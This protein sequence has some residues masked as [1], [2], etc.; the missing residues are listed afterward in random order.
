MH[1]ARYVAAAALGAGAA[2]SEFAALSGGEQ[3]QAEV[4]RALWWCEEGYLE[5][6]AQ[7]EGG[8]AQKEGGPREGCEGSGGEA[9]IDTGAS[10]GA[11]SGRQPA[12]EGIPGRER[13][14]L[15]DEFGSSWDV[16]TASRVAAALA[17]AVRDPRARVAGAVLASCHLG[18]VAALQPDWVFEAASA[19]LLQPTPP[20]HASWV[21]VPSAE[22]PPPEE[23]EGSGDCGSSG[24]CAGGAAPTPLLD[25]P[26]GATLTEAATDI[27]P[28]S[29]IGLGGGIAAWEVAARR[30]ASGAAR[31]AASVVVATP[32]LDLR[33]RRCGAV[34]WRRFSALH[35]KSAALSTHA[36]MRAHL[37]TARLGEGPEVHSIVDFVERERWLT[38]TSPSLPHTLTPSHPRTLVPSHR[39]TLVLSHPRPCQVPC[40]FV[41]TI[42]HSGKRSE[43]ARAPSRRAHRTVV[44]AEWQG[45]GIGSRLSDA[46]AEW[47][48][49]E[50]ADYYGQT[51][52]PSF[53]GYRD[54]SPLWQPTEYNGTRPE[55]RIE[56]WRAR[57]RGVAVRLRTPKL[58]YSHRYC[59][60]APGDEVASRHLAGRVGFTADVEGGAVGEVRDARGASESSSSK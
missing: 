22:L 48:H 7:P 52:H 47:H 31:G 27:P 23:V 3:A 16:D 14:L 4:A 24:G 49:R 30:A 25:L 43:G 18:F 37:L 19:T 36:A 39:R 20:S 40:G 6:E 15:L 58:I 35:Y 9:R 60:A 56:G 26:R 46:A 1:A 33:M 2:G 50:G 51:V 28:L 11:A 12:R 17:A 29:H 41:A 53:G 32:Q 13:L 8:G 42:L 21:G 38:L 10:G 57:Q 55:L 34:E 5:E 54:R 44:L 59:G 45:L